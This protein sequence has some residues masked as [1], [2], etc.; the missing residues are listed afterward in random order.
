MCVKK[1]ANLSMEDA[2]AA[3]GVLLTSYEALVRVA[4]IAPG[5]RVLVH[6]ASG[7]VGL[8]ALQLCKFYGCEIFATV[9]K[10]DKRE[11][12]INQMGIPADHIFSS[13]SLVFADQVKKFFASYLKNTDY[14]THQR[15][16]RRCST[17]LVNGRR[18]SAL[19]P[20]SSTQGAVY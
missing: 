10:K 5:E 11:Y 15:G 14:G 8:T 12:L 3:T 1:P 2:V 18:P 6:L 13:R 17:Q 20:T 4:H 9:G 7:G 19:F 16:R